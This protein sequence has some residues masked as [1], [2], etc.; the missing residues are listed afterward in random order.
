MTISYEW[1]I[2]RQNASGSA[3]QDCT[4]VN[5]TWSFNDTFDTTNNSS[6][7]GTSGSTNS[8]SVQT[9]ASSSML[10]VFDN[11]NGWS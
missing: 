10:S 5:D 4:F 3:L 8:G 9:D 7:N 2:V 11:T 6:N 1:I